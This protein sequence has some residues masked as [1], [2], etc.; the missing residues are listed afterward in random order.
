MNST[1]KRRTERIIADL[2]LINKVLQGADE[3]ELK[4][5]H[6]DLDG[7]YQSCIKDWG[8]GMY[9]HHPVYGFIYDHLGVDSLKDNLR[10]MRAKLDA[11]KEG[12]NAFPASD[13]QNNINVTIN[14][15]ISLDVSFNQARSQ[16]DNM[17][18]LTDSETEDIKARIDEL[19]AIAK[20]SLGKKKKWEKIKP[21]IAFAMDKGVDVA[22]VFMSLVLQ[23]K[24]L[25]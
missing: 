13:S 24:L 5:V 2:N 4:R 3:E 14:N 15:E 22:I 16:M 17:A 6:R 7:R 21:I 23:M 25:G 1:E 9:A 10:L 19:E 8:M 12:W 11:F 18:G 20:E